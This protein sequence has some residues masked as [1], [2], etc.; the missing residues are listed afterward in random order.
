MNAQNIL[1]FINK[2][3]ELLN[4]HTIFNH[5]HSALKL[6]SRKQLHKFYTLEPDT[7]L[8]VRHFIFNTSRAMW[9]VLNIDSD[10]NSIL[11]GHS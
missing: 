1:K 5:F 10:V 8:V 11:K 7:G 9:I 6:N 2:V 3:S 4:F